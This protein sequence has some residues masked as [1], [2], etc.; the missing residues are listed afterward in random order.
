M[1]MTNA[2]SL[3]SP[4]F[5]TLRQRIVEASSSERED[6]YKASVIFYSKVLP[7]LMGVERCTIFIMESRSNRI[8]SMFGTGLEE[9][10][11]EAPLEGSIVG[12]V[13]STG[14][15][16]VVNDFNSQ[17]G[18]HTRIAE[19]TGFICHNTLCAPIKG[20]GE[21]RVY[22]AIQLLNK[23]DA[24]GFSEGD[25]LMLEEVACLLSTSIETISLNQEIL[26]IAD[27]LGREV[28]RLAQASVRGQAFIADSPAMREV[29][30]MV[31]VVSKTPVNV[32]LLGENG[33]GKELL[34]RMIHEKGERRNNPFVPVNCACIPDTLIE[35]E[36]FGHEKGAFTGAEHSRKGRF[37]ESSGGTLF[38]DEIA[39]MQLS[40][41]PKFLREIEEQEGRRLGGN[42]TISYDLRLIS[43]TNKEIMGAVR[44]GVC[45]EDRYFRLFSVERIVPPLRKRPEDIIPL[46]LH[47][48]TQTCTRFDK[49][50]AGFSN[51]LLRLFE[52]Y[53]WPGNVRQLM[54]EVERLVALTPSGRTI[55]T[56]S[57]SSSLLDFH[58]K[59]KEKRKA[60][61][62]FDS[63]SIPDQ[64]ERLEKDLIGKALMRTSGNK[65]QAAR[66]LSLTR[67]GLAQKL[68]RY[69]IST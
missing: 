10:S 13:I 17:S 43:A 59:E 46:A 24:S 21:S 65:S 53:P 30:N 18:Y 28:D 14:E 62:E 32:M 52:R 9:I 33:T 2:L 37:E 51:E 6:D 40:V 16:I 47:F 41:Q 64:V 20:R 67:Q 45:R 39:D 25:R 56:A 35:S 57:C 19:Q 49:Q 5:S 55:Q 27:Y 44:K 63:L 38:L 15:S 66:L 69:K 34:A 4:D 48:L 8:C 60:E 36:F 3:S 50:V 68:K 11:I 1:T 12:K 7:K 61:E 58:E 31:E 29:L 23:S 22:G 26:R 42:T 54:R